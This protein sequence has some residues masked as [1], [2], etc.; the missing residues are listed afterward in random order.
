MAQTRTSVIDLKLSKLLQV[1]AV[2]RKR[3]GLVL[4]QTPLE[5]VQILRQC[6]PKQNEKDPRIPLFLPASDS[7]E[8]TT[9]K[10]KGKQC[11]KS[12][13]G[14]PRAPDSSPPASTSGIGMESPS[15]SPSGP[16]RIRLRY[17]QD[18]NQLGEILIS[19]TC[20]FFFSD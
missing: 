6:H 15:E 20:P 13:R 3:A 8:D 9:P 14:L 4:P 2:D 12:I 1:I 16:N 5:A 10:G 19:L 7:G 11:H 17:A 18:V